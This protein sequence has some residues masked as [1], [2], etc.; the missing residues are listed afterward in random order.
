MDDMAAMEQQ[1]S[2][3]AILTC[4][5]FLISFTLL[6][7]SVMGASCPELSGRYLL[8]GEDGQ[9]ELVI[10][11]IGCQTVTVIRKA[12]YLGKASIERHNLKID[13]RFHPDTPW[14]GGKDKVRTSADFIGD[15]LEIT[16]APSRDGASTYWKTRYELLPNK[17]LSLAEFQKT[18]Q[19][20]SPGLVAHRQY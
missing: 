3:S 1:V 10:Q 15:A 2:R 19:S 11:Q 17:D 5:A 14:F 18:T 4:S 8:Q 12:S 20:Y 13:G 6:A 9:V 7:A 16:V